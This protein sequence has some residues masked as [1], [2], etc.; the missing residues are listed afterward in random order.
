MT[1]PSRNRLK[2]AHFVDGEEILDDVLAVLIDGTTEE[3]VELHTHGGPEIVERVITVLERRGAAV[4][5]SGDD[6]TWPATSL[7]EL[8][9]WRALATARTG[10]A[11][12]FLAYQQN[13]LTAGLEELARLAESG[14]VGS[15]NEGLSVLQDQSSGHIRLLEGAT[16]VI[17]GPPNAGKSTLFNYLAGEDR[18]ITSDLPGTT[19]DWVTCDCAI[20]GLPVTLIDTAGVRTTPCA[21]E[22]ESIRRGNN[23]ATAA[24]L[25]VLLLDATEPIDRRLITA[26]QSSRS[27]ASLIVAQNKSDLESSPQQ[28]IERIDRSPQTVRVSAR[29]GDGIDQLNRMMLDELKIL[30][31]DD[32]LGL[33][34]QRQRE[35]I[36]RLLSDEFAEGGYLADGIR[37]FLIRG[38]DGDAEDWQS[39]TRTTRSPAAE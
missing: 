36:Q 24:D 7:I 31:D 13:H 22:A 29:T 34:T 6:Q 17:A 30:S 11:A 4:V 32:H 33:F 26:Y 21:L 39:Y 19:R 5:E 28:F 8:E 14:R 20:D 35:T 16:I 25:V 12:R 37:R 18:A 38:F 2:Y 10:R 9:I 3:T 1:A 15:T 27:T 23:Q